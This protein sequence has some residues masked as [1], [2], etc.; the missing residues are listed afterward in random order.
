[1]F[2]KKLIILLTA[3]ILLFASAALAEETFKTDEAGHPV[4]ENFGEASLSSPG[5]YTLDKCFTIVEYRNT[6]YRMTAG[7]DEQA[8][9]LWN[10]SLSTDKEKASEATDALFDYCKILPVKY[11]GEFSAVPLKQEEL[12]KLVGKTL[13]EATKEGFSYI[14]TH[15]YEEPDSITFTLDKGYFQY[16]IELDISFEEYKDHLKQD[17]FDDLTIKSANWN[18]SFSSLAYGRDVN[19]D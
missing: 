2:L 3:L 13:K 5:L 1:M 18:G 17:D 9:D 14:S 8:K 16:V 6:Y 7:Y 4:F 12:D 11:D 15:Y 19:H 10:D